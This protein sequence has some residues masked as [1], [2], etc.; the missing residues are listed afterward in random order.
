[1]PEQKVR[2]IPQPVASLDPAVSK[3]QNINAS[4]QILD[5]A[6]FGLNKLLDLIETGDENRERQTLPNP[7]SLSEV[8]SSLP[9]ILDSYSEVINNSVAK[10]R[11]L[12]F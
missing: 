12:L 10:I 3:H 8:L 7:G 2:A 11:S 4:I 5:D 6:V 1:M 9:Q